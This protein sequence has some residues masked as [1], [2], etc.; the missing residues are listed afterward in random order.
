MRGLTVVMGLLAVT[1]S[2]R[3][4]PFVN[5]ENYFTETHYELGYQAMQDMGFGG[6][7]ASGGG[8]HL[9]EHNGLLSRGP[10]VLF[11]LLAAAGAGGDT[12]MV[13]GVT[14]GT[15]ETDITYVGPNGNVVDTGKVVS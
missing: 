1:S 4:N 10:Y 5:P 14:T 7:M 2:A 6:G 12:K 8:L 13:G 15:K 9:T 11:F 3:A